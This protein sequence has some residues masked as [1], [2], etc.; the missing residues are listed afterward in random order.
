MTQDSD[1]QVTTDSS[2]NK[3]VPSASVSTQDSDLSAT[4]SPATGLDLYNAS[5]SGDLETVMRIISAGHVNI[6]YRG[7]HSRTPV[8]AAAWE[9]QSDVVE[10]LVGSG[11]DVSLLDKSGNNILH[12]AC[13]GAGDLETVE[14]ILSLNLLDINSREQNKRTPVMAAAWKGHRGVVE[15]LVVRGADVSLVDGDG[16]NILHLACWGAGDLETVE[17]ILSLNKVD[18][19]SRGL[20]ARTPVM[21]AAWKGHRDVVE[22]LVGRGADVSLVA[23]DGDNV[24]HYACLGGDL[25]TVKLILLLNK[26]DINARNNYGQTAADKARGGGHQQVLDLLV[27][28]GTH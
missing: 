5:R 6:N 15:L 16:D 2:P 19:N 10:F 1:L 9:G 4:P 3:T 23:K 22:L 13:W 17:L 21:L 26:V 18:I 25:E 7:W 12:L 28:R 8:M 14:L 20:W 11:A 24:L 27:S